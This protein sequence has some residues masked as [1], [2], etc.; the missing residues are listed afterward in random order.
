M[1][2]A[3]TKNSPNISAFSPELTKSGARPVCSERG[4][5]RQASTRLIT[6]NGTLMANS[7]SQ[8]ATAS[9]PEAMVGPNAAAADTMSAFRPTPRPREACG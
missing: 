5:A 7:H 8:F 1:V 6:P 2:S 9:M 3:P 4:R